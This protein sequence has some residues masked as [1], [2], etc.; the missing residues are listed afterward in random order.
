MH[1]CNNYSLLLAPRG[2]LGFSVGGISDIQTRIGKY[3]VM[4]E[5]IKAVVKIINIEMG[6]SEISR[7][8]VY[9]ILLLTFSKALKSP[10]FR[11][12]YTQT[13]A[14]LLKKNLEREKIERLEPIIDF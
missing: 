10:D 8:I 14:G 4:N 11:T 13:F 7:F 9:K 3:K 6:E 2:A 12:F 1:K 5:I